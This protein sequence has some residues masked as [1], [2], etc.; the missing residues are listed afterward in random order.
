VRSIS[1]VSGV[2]QLEVDFTPEVGPIKAVQKR[3]RPK[4]VKYARAGNT[5]DGFQLDLSNAEKQR[6]L[7]YTVEQQKIEYELDNEGLLIL[8]F[9]RSLPRGMFIKLILY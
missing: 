1:D 2:T 3:I 8:S 4:L 5:A 9:S 6:S 7:Q